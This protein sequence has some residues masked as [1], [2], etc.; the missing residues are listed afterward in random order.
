MTRG[1]GGISDT[2]VQDLCHLDGDTEAGQVKQTPKVTQL[3][4]SSFSFP[5]SRRLHRNS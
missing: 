4:G 3:G 1:K 5:G 2:I